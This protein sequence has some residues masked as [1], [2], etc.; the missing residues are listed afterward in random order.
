MSAE[1]A[2]ILK[3]F[4][5]TVTIYINI[6]PVSPEERT[7]I[8]EMYKAGVLSLQTAL[9]ML[10]VDDAS[11]E[12]ERIRSQPES[13]QAQMK[14]KAELMGVFIRDCQLDQVTAA[15]LA[16][17]PPELVAKIK[18]AQADL[19]AEREEEERR[20]REEGGDPANRPPGNRPPGPP[21]QRKPEDAAA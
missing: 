2:D 8:L 1:A 4:K 12:I 17:F 21:A 14:A 20:L 10:Q 18:A 11:A 7:A 13:Q 6:G 9:L 16:G 5:V 19:E 15:E 3:R